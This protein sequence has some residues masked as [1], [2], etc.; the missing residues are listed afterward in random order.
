MG[1]R[2]RRPSTII[3]RLAQDFVQLM[4]CN[5]QFT[6]D[7]CLFAFHRAGLEP[8][9][10]AQKSLS[11]AQRFVTVSELAQQQGYLLRFRAGQHHN[12]QSACK[13]NFARLHALEEQAFEF[14]AIFWPVAVDAAATTLPRDAWLAEFS[15]GHLETERT[16]T[17][18][19]VARLQLNVGKE[20]AIAA[21]AAG[22]TKVARI[23][24]IQGNRKDG[25]FAPASQALDPRGSLCSINTQRASSRRWE[26]QSGTT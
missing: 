23:A 14:A 1:L 21:Q 12:V 4:E 16:Q 15:A 26:L 10:G 20:D 18:S 17:D 19:I 22:Q 7:G 25:D 2:N 11:Q 5:R 8:P 24:G 6:I 13:W 9:G 3:K